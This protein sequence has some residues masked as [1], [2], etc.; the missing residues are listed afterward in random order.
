M[1]AKVRQSTDEVCSPGPRRVARHIAVTV[2]G[3][4]AN[5][6]LVA[7]LALLP[8]FASTGVAADRLEIIAIPPAFPEV[9]GETWTI[10]LHGH[11]DIAAGTRL[12]AAV[13]SHRIPAGSSIFLNSPGGSLVG[14]IELGR[15]IREL[16]LSTNIGAAPGTTDGLPQSGSCYSACALAFVGG[17]FRYQ[18]WG[19]SSFGVHQFYLDDASILGSH[20]E[21]LA[22]GQ[23]TSSVVVQYLAEM[24]VSMRLLDEMV[25]A[26]GSE[27]NVLSPAQM[28]EMQV[29]NNGQLEPEWELRVV[30]EGTYLSAS[31][32][33]EN[34]EGKLLFMCDR[35]QRRVGI[36]AMLE[37]GTQEQAAMASA[38]FA[39]GGLIL[40]GAVL[41]VA[42]KDVRPISASNSF[43]ATEWLPSDELLTAILG[44]QTIGYRYFPLNPDFYMGFEFSTAGATSLL[45]PFAAECTND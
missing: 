11:I 13:E 43:T 26:S 23:L 31:Q 6:L 9:L 15:S 40:N 45:P 3:R 36:I 34:G 21:A 37:T 7:V 14:G 18:T 41:D 1:V 27:I 28:V 5:I 33:T 12:E 29:A 10:Y 17:V 20:E 42:G 4:A 25:R 16:G 39:E 2:V 32:V 19:G 30:P 8:A 44:A 22:A 38:S 24:G 35:M